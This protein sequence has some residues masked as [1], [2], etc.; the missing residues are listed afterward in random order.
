LA[1]VLLYPSEVAGNAVIGEI[2]R[3]FTDS[4]GPG[5]MIIFLIGALAATFSTA[6]NYF[7][8]WPR[9]VAACCRNLFRTTAALPGIAVHQLTEAHRGTWSSEYNVYRLTMVY[10]LAAAVLIIAGLPRPVFLVLVSSAL[11]FFIAPVIFFLNLYYCF[12]VIPKTDRV[13]YPSRFAT[14]F[15][16]FSLVVFTG[17]TVVV[18]I[19]RIYQ[20]LVEMLGG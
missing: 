20:P 8:G 6:F 1:A 2:A 15:S 17:L 5:A 12:T 13:F 16:W 9:V 19:A 7:D 11:A 4:I 10:S 14:W 18:I 3:I